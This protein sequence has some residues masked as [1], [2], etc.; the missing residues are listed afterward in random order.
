MWVYVH[1]VLDLVLVLCL[2]QEENGDTALHIAVLLFNQISVAILLDAGADASWE[3]FSLDSPVHFA[4]R[5][6]NLP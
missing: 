6:G 2:L 3:N 4:A 1:C 5:I